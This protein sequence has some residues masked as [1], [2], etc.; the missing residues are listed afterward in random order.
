MNKHVRL[1]LFILLS[2]IFFC[3]AANGVAQEDNV[4]VNL[5]NASLKEVFTAIEKQTTY[6]FSYRD[7]V[8]DPLKNISIS[9][10]NATVPSV[11]DEAMSGRNLTYRI[12]SQESIVISDKR[13]NTGTPRN[14]QAET[15][16]VS[17]VVKDS[18]G[19]PLIGASVTEEENPSNGATTD[20]DGNFN[21]TVSSLNSTLSISYIGFET[22]KI[23]LTGEASVNVVL[24]EQVGLLDEIVVVGYGTQRR[25]SVTGA[26]ASIQTEELT[27]VPTAN[28][29][30]SLSGKLPGL[31]VVARTGMPGANDATIDIRGFGA[32]LII[33][34][35]IPVYNNNTNGMS[36]LDPNEIESISVLKD[37]AA[38]VYGVK[39]ANGVMLITT[40]RGK[41]GKTTVNLSS[42]FSWQRPTVYPEMANAAQFVE[43]TDENAINRGQSPV[44]GKETLAKY[45]AGGAGYESYDWYKATVRDWSPMQQ[46]NMN[47]RGGTDAISYFTSAGY[48]NEEGMWKSGDLSHEKFNFRANV[49]AKLKG[50]FSTELS[51]SGR[52]EETNSPNQTITNITAGIQKNYPIYSPYANNNEKYY[53]VTNS[54]FNPL[55]YTDSD[56]VGYSQDLKYTFEGSMALKYDAS[57]FIKGLSAKASFYYRYTN[58]SD[59]T[60]LRKFSLYA[61]DEATDTYNGQQVEPTSRISEIF[62]KDEAKNFQ[63]S[64]NY[65]NV[66]GKHDVTGMLV[67]EVRQNRESYISAGRD[68]IIDAID[69]ISS[70]KSDGATNSGTSYE[71]ANIGYVGRFTY[72]FDQRY[73]MEFSFRYDGSS[74]FPK[75]GRWGFFPSVSA[76][77]RISEESFIKNRYDFIDNLKLRAGWGRLGDESDGWNSYSYVTGYTYPSGNYIFGGSNLTS[78]LVDRGL[79]NPYLTWFTSE[80]YNAG[81]DFGF[82]NGKLS[83]V[84]D[85]FYRKRSGLL[86]TRAS[87]L[88]GTFGSSFPQENL[89]G[90]SHR[91]FELELGHT[92]TL[93]NGLTY[94]IKGSMS[95]TRSRNEYMERTPS[96]YQWHNWYQNTSYRWKNRTWGYTAIGQFQSYDEIAS[97]PAQDGVGN[98]TLFPGDIKYLDYNDDGVIDGQDQHLIGRNNMP[99]Y[100]FGLDLSA[101]WKGF[102]AAVFF[103]GATNLNVTYI[104]ELATPFF[105][106]ENTLAVFADRWHREDIYDPKSAWVPGKYPSTYS[107][108]KA[109]NT[110]IS[111]FWM[112]DCS[113]LRLKELQLG[114]TIPTKLLSKACI[115]SFRMFVA[116]YN[117]FTLTEADLLDP[118]SA[119]TDGRYYPQQKS[120]SFGFNLTF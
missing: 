49:D 23:K 3:N 60:L 11:L 81:I 120:V 111:T 83:G 108:G 70:G 72:A 36:Q 53:A 115:E 21:I 35:G 112:Q 110:R 38:A 44:Y 59:K 2:V 102:D 40:K 94:S 99:E 12:V 116:G 15:G 69:E 80:M 64:I 85:V 106:G 96:E 34:D 54:T 77:W 103:Q 46:Y 42:T 48:Q 32:P 27:R 118:E 66:F 101:S 75:D 114:Y 58:I 24:N 105:N 37:A 50:G 55:A 18:N 89:N 91:G 1:R 62:Y 28:L 84:L 88:P 7:V 82:W 73:L 41:S 63:A 30:N 51:V 61:Y 26:V 95:Y 117:L 68:F 5:K 76:G 17:G 104:N 9:K 33:I 45:Q 109:N 57:E 79:A 71:L 22:K 74:K 56:V 25:G 97:S 19:D 90:D 113:Y 78:G 67:S 43:L 107:S 65:A 52:R 6:R 29:S 86:A 4:T 119:S 20:I 31:R 92:N 14:N 8:I 47:I 13:Q 98:T 16:R 93:E 87:S 39:A 100:T 10:A